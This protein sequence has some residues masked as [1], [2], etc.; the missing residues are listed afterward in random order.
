MFVAERE[1]CPGPDYQ[2]DA[3]SVVRA[4]TLGVIF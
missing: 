3:Y 1:A 4:I 2:K